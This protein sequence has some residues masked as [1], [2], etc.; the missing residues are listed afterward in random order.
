MVLNGLAIKLKGNSLKNNLKKIS[1]NQNITIGYLL[2]ST[3]ELSRVE[4]N[5]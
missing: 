4:L 5:S 3:S 1:K 2:K